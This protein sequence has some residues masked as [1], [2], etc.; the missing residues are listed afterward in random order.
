VTVD[1]QPVDFQMS[2]RAQALR[3]ELTEF[4]AGRVIPCESAYAEQ[5]RDSGDPHHHPEV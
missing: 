3:D 1:A 4:M 5:M 2:D